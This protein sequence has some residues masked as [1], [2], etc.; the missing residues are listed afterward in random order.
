[1]VDV[2]PSPAGPPD[3]PEVPWS[4]ATAISL[5]RAAFQ[6]AWQDL[7]LQEVLFAYYISA[8]QL[9]VFARTRE[10]TVR[11]YDVTP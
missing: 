8:T 4:D 3:K 9:R 6:R 10:N 1:M 2:L 7:T 11:T 5:T